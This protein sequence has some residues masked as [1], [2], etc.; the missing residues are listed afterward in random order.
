MLDYR[1]YRQLNDATWY[2]QVIRFN[3]DDEA[4]SYGLAIRTENRCELYEAERWIATFDGVWQHHHDGFAPANENAK[5][6][7]VEGAH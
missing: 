1:F 7:E 3:S 4:I 5:P 6:N 2:V